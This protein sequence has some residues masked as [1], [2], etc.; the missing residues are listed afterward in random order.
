MADEHQTTQGF[1]V[2]PRE[3]INTKD[4]EINYRVSKPIDC[5]KGVCKITMTLEEF[6]RNELSICGPTDVVT[7]RL[8]FTCTDAKQ[9][10]ACAVGSIISG[11]ENQNAHHMRG[12]FNHTSNSYNYGQQQIVTMVIDDQVSRQ[13]QPASSQALAFRFYLYLSKG[14]EAVVEADFHVFGP[15]TRYA[16][17]FAPQTAD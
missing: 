12:A 9:K 11:F 13:I 7:L 10:V 5:S 8:R 4:R 1:S 3:P 15:I 16:E 6:M 2:A 14:V 17:V